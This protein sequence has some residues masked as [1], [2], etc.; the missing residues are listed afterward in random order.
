MQRRGLFMVKST[1]F[2]GCG[3]TPY[4][5]RLPNVKAKKDKT[6]PKMERKGENGQTGAI[7]CLSF[8]D[9]PEM[10]Q[11]TLGYTALT[12]SQAGSGHVSEWRGLETSIFRPIQ[13]VFC[14]KC[15][16]HLVPE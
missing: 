2:C 3:D 9:G 8:L 16:P 4:Q 11:M 6:P 5:A 13:G 7:S 12:S 15:F 1:V 14:D 10:P